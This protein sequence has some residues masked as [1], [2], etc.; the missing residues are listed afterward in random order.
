MNVADW[1]NGST[2]AFEA[3]SVG[4][5]PASAAESGW[6]PQSIGEAGSNPAESTIGL[7]VIYPAE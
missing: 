6:I 4:S 5:N 2:D 3:L 7:V 1:C